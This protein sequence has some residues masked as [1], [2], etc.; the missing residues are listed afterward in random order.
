MFVLFALHYIFDLEY[1]LRLK[2]FYLLLRTSC[3]VSQPRACCKNTPNYS[4]VTSAQS[5]VSLKKIHSDE[6]YSM[7][8]YFFIS[9][10]Y[11]EI[12]DSYLIVIMVLNVIIITQCHVE[13]KAGLHVALK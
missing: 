1:N 8:Y 11:H 9:L 12:I 7:T 4:S 10:N 2:D 5:S 3:F 6:S 13:I